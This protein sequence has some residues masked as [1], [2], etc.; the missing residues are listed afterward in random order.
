M[1]YVRRS[2]TTVTYDVYDHEQ[3]LGEM[4]V[5]CFRPFCGDTELTKRQMRDIVDAMNKMF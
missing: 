4:T 2:Y 3:L 1:R 5:K